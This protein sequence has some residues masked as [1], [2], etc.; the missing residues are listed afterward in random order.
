[1]FARS[2]L[3]EPRNFMEWCQSEVFFFRIEVFNYEAGAHLYEVA[4]F[5]CFR[6]VKFVCTRVVSN[7]KCIERRPSMRETA[8][9]RT[10]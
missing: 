8:T 2:S 10:R 5:G 6:H 9:T 7:L 4:E 1:M 3:T